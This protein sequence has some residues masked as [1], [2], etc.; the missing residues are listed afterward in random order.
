MFQARKQHLYKLVLIG[1]VLATVL[2]PGGR[3]YAQD[4]YLYLPILNLGN[5]NQIG[6]ALTNSTVFEIDVELTV[7]SEKGTILAVPQVS[8]PASL[9]LP[10]RGQTARLLRE[11]FGP[12]I[13]DKRGWIEVSPSDPGVNG[14]GTL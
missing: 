3:L 5:A 4:G 6:V 13:V 8:N 7:Y 14:N 12:G 10:P 9:T 11:I 1:F 2:L